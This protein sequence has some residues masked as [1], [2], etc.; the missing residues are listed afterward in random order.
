MPSIDK[1]SSLFCYGINDKENIFKTL[2]TEF[3]SGSWIENVFPQLR[4]N[5]EIFGEKIIQVVLQPDQVKTLYF[6]P[7]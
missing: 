3:Q 1:H 7:Q 2:L 6:F 5:F 4:E